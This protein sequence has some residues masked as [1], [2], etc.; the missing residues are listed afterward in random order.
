MP[1]IFLAGDVLVRNIPG[2][3]FCSA[4]V[5]RFIENADY[6]LANFEAPI[7]GFGRPASKYGPHLNQMPEAV[8]GLKQQGFKGLLLA[9][10]HAL[11]YGAEGLQATMERIDR[12]GLDRTGAGMTREEA[13][14]PLIKEIAGSRVG[15][16]NVAEAQFGVLDH[17]VGDRTA[18]YAWINHPEIDAR[19][20]KLAGECDFTIVLAHAG[21]EHYRIPQMEW[22]LRYRRFCDLGADAV[23]A[24]HPHTPQG[25]ERH[26]ESLIFYSL[27]NFFFAAPGHGTRTEE[28]F[29]IELSLQ[30]G[31]A[32]TFK[33]LFHRQENG[34]LVLVEDNPETYFAPL[35]DLLGEAYLSEWE[36]MSLREYERIRNWQTYA[37]VPFLARGNIRHSLRRLASRI[38]G[39]SGKLNKQQL[40]LHLSRNESY[41]YAARH[42][43]TL[44]TEKAAKPISG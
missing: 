27:G 11:D 1:K 16:F 41:R 6:A 19:L 37:L 14:R 29:S 3:L 10:N 8:E 36:K 17:L 12:V 25:Y 43:L 22:R 42:A 24:A 18:G 7:A 20:E 9:N 31:M 28:S 5:Q 15:F 21:L 23:V 4:P 39:R 30:K 26:G 32:P 40:L 33:P 34:K 38:L 35:N 44:K 2:G 13:Y